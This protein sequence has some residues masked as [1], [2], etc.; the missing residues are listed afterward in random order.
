MDDQMI[1]D[2]FKARDLESKKILAMAD[3]IQEDRRR[4]EIQKKTAR[5][6]AATRSLTI[7]LCGV[8]IALG[9]SSLVCMHDVKSFV[10]SLLLVLIAALGMEVADIWNG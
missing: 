1:F 5:C 6:R 2:L 8:V 4:S 10:I 9:V 3:E 7:F